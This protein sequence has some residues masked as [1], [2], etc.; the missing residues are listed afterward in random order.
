L[1]D[2]TPP[3]DQTFSL[4]EG[5]LT[6]LASTYIPG[7]AHL[8]SSRP[9]TGRT[10]YVSRLGDEVPV[11]RCDA[12]VLDPRLAR[13]VSAGAARRGDEDFLAWVE[14]VLVAGGTPVILLEIP[15]M[16][17]RVGPLLLE[18]GLGVAATRSVARC[19]ARYRALGLG[20]PVVSGLPASSRAGRPVLASLVRGRSRL[21]EPCGSARIAALV[22]AGDA[23]P[24]VTGLDVEVVLRL[25]HAAGLDAYARLVDGCGA[26][27]VQ[28]G[29]GLGALPE[30]ST[31]VGVRWIAAERQARLVRSP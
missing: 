31:R 8:L 27:V 25:K 14:E 23:E 20:M 22:D 28:C 3:L 15:T 24:H 12:L 13:P 5:D 21:G 9:D 2:L 26:D 4:G 7:A 16:L 10:L 11:T 17:A 19:A 6:L 30:R 1:A 18:A 29:L